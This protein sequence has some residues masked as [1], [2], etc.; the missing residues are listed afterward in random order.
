MNL[1]KQATE[2]YSGDPFIDCV[3]QIDSST[4]TLKKVKGKTLITAKVI[5]TGKEAILY[6]DKTWI[7]PCG[8]SE[9]V[10]TQLTKGVTI[11]EKQPETVELLC[12]NNEY[13]AYFDSAWRFPFLD[14]SKRYYFDRSGTIYSGVTN[15]I[16]L[17]PLFDKSY[18]AKIAHEKALD[19][20]NVYPEWSILADYGTLLHT[21]VSMHEINDTEFKFSFD[22]N[23]QW[24]E[25]L[26]DYATQKG[27]SHLI[28]KWINMIQN[29]MAAWFMFKKDR[30]VKV[31]LSEVCVKDKEIGIMTP[32]DIVCEMDFEK[33]RQIATINIKSGKSIAYKDIQFQSYVET[34]LFNRMLP[35]NKRAT[36]S[37]LWRPKDR[38]KS[39]CEY[40]IS[41][42]LISEFNNEDV[43]MLG[44]CVEARGLN[45]PK[46]TILHISGTE[47]NMRIVKL[48]AEEYVKLFLNLK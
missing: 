44:Y 42:N 17:H 12:N 10:T 5:E 39:P 37:L 23:K 20:I 38:S 43:K 48:S 14:T 7:D 22:D 30:N 9:P 3:G 16:S 45:K 34:R 21:F 8:N 36:L 47:D 24:I 46:G 40:E 35:E 11:V 31:L 32:V 26:K 28:P 27:Y 41:K 29:D 2:K 1:R 19:G 6:S 33:K 25:Y 13:S 15:A 18:L 4:I